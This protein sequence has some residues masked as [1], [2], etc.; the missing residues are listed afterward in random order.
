MVRS[1]AGRSERLDARS[2]AA[3]ASTRAVWITVPDPHVPVVEARLAAWLAALAPKPLPVVV[4]AAGSLRPEVL[5]RCR[6]L[7]APVA[8]AHPIVSFGTTE[9]DL[10]GAT[11]LLAGDAR[12]TRVLSSIVRTLGARPLVR[13]LPG[14]RYHAALALLANGAAAL[15]DRA[16]SI[17]VSGDPGL[18]PLEARRA[19]GRLL[20]SVADN[21]ERVGAAG[22]LTGP[23][24]RGDVQAV[25]RHLAALDHEE[26]ADYVAA[27][28]LILRAA[29]SAGLEPRA[30]RAIATALDSEAA[31]GV[32]A[33][34][35]RRAA[36]PASRR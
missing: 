29:S 34:R 31:A 19:L 36:R 18:S 12:A 24:A 16:T 17:L 27:S 28:R 35:G 1:I 14:P 7:G 15:A 3:L 11:F 26:Q 30:A 2:R 13:A 23:I 25:E 10:V 6:A 33:S 9:T 8:T 32:S 22:A 20:R 5:G 21:V 4:H